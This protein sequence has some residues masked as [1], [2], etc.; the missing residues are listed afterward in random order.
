MDAEQDIRRF[1][2]EQTGWTEPATALTADYPLVENGVLDSLAI[3][4]VVTF[5][6]DR[7]QIEIDDE[8][9][10]PENFETINDIVRIVTAKAAT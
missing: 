3:F 4:Q 6:E 5:L 7:Y 8:E 1:I 9:L 2:I 10:V